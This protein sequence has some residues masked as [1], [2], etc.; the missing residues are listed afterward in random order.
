M[1]YF[2]FWCLLKGAY[3]KVVGHYGTYLMEL[4]KLAKAD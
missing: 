2:A 3:Y 4:N 1:Y